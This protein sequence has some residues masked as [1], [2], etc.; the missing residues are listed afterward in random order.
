M[1]KNTPRLN[2]ERKKDYIE[3]HLFNELRWLLAAATEWSIQN[4]LNLGMVGYD[5]QVYAMDSAF[6]HARALFEFVV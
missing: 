5:V 3:Q 2:D 6:L 4:Q 1:G